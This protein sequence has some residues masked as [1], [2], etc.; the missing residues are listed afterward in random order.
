MQLSHLAPRFAGA[1]LI[2]VLSLAW[3]APAASAAP[4][5]HASGGFDVANTYT[6][7]LDAGQQLPS[8]GP[9][10][11]WYEV[12]GSSQ[13]LVATNSANAKIVK[14]GMSRPTYSQCKNAPV[15]HRQ[16]LFT[17]LP[18]NVW[19]CGLTDQGRVTRFQLQDKTQ[20]VIHFAFTTWEHP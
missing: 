14:W 13:W 16:Y 18:R 15:K 9:Y 12:D 6:F 8:P 11:V 20:P 19:L 7:D 4:A 3:L 10:D 17:K 1:M 2:A 5:V